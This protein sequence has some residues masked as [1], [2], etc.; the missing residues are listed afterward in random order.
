MAERPDR[1]T[2][3]CLRYVDGRSMAEM[4]EMFG[5]GHGTMAGWLREYRV[6]TPVEEITRRRKAAGVA[7]AKAQRARKAKAGLRPAPQMVI[8]GTDP[9]EMVARA[10]AAGWVPTRGEPAYAAVSMSGRIWPRGRSL[11]S[12][13]TGRQVSQRVPRA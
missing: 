3:Y 5:V 10:L 12:I 4:C 11:V 9:A 13:E 6:P 7:S 2:L 1:D 8:T